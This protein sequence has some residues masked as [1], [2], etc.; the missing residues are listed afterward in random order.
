MDNPN[1]SNM[2]RKESFMFS[3]RSLV[4]RGS[5]IRVAVPI[6]IGT[7]AA[8][9]ML[10]AGNARANMIQN[11]DFSANASD[12]VTYPGYTSYGNGSAGITGWTV[13]S[14]GNDGINGPD[15]GFYSNPGAGNSPEPF[16]PT[17]TA[18]VRDF[19]FMQSTGASASQSVSTSAGQEYMLS[20]DAAAR[21]GE[22][23]SD[24]IE[25][26]LTDL[27]GNTQITS[28]S[29]AI[30]DTG[31]NSFTVNFTA[32]SASTA[33]EFLN[34]SSYSSGTVDVSNVSLAAVPEPATLG[35]FAIGGLGL[36]ML[37]RRKAV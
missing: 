7:A 3:H 35:V 21:S 1:S 17:S 16:A 26:I 32:P 5:A 28:Q 18:G 23:G 33:V 34:N 9:A 20:Y 6:A 11:G 10:S 27:V 29:P 13:G 12:F 8:L 37:K 4:S 31:F 14:T 30:A 19:L 25:V 24:A 15:T 22:A 36:L 2:E